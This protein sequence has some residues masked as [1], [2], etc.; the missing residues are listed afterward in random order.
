MFCSES[1]LGDTTGNLVF[2]G[3]VKGRVGLV[4]Q[5]LGGNPQHRVE[6]RGRGFGFVQ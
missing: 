6:V 3:A 4:I 1:F 5:A 2:I